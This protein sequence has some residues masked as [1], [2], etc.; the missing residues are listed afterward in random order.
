MKPVNPEQTYM[1]EQGVFY[2]Q[3][4]KFKWFPYDFYPTQAAALKSA[5]ANFNSR[6]VWRI[7]FMQTVSVSRRY[8]EIQKKELTNA[9]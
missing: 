1:L 3:T 8:Q 6:T 7:R 2:P 9:A 5:L 4:S